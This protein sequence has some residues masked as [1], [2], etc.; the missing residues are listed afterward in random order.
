MGKKS[1]TPRYPENILIKS[2]VVERGLSQEEIA[3]KL[4][5]SRQIINRTLNGHHKGENI[6]P[7]IKDLLK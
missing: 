4:D 5:V 6:I 1:L 3:L 2:Q 7:R